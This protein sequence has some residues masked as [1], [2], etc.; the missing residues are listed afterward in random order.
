MFTGS[1]V[2]DICSLLCCSDV[3]TALTPQITILQH[4]NDAA[5]SWVIIYVTLQWHTSP[6]D[7]CIPCKLWRVKTLMVMCHDHEEC[8]GTSHHQEQSFYTRCVQTADRWAHRACA[9]QTSQVAGSTVSQRE[10]RERHGGTESGR[11]M[12]RPGVKTSQDTKWDTGIIT[13]R[14]GHVSRVQWWTQAEK[15]WDWQQL[16]ST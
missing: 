4:H 6:Y 10:P 9:H 16:I 12:P 11:G 1:G 14:Q 5:R 8:L 2:H 13:Q 3:F 7:T 15:K